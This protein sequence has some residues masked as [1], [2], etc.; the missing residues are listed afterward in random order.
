MTLLIVEDEPKTAKLL[1]KGLIEADF[2]VEIA[3]NGQQA[4]RRARED[5]YD[6]IILDLML[7]GPDG[8]SILE[9]L[10]RL[11]DTTPVLIL[12]ARDGIQ[13][14]VRGLDV[15]ADDYMVK[16]FAVAELL[17]RIRALLRRSPQRQSETLRV[18]DLELDLLSHRA[19]RGA[20]RLDLTPTEFRLLHL[21]AQRTGEVIPRSLI[22]ERV[23]KMDSIPSPNLVDVHVRRLRSKVDDPF[24]RKLVHTVR[25]VGY[26]I[27]DRG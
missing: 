17:A 3:S 23:W 20:V 11:G 14:R 18:G 25:G 13:D 7:P 27:E 15:G 6:A 4:L 8:M 26:V 22:A 2:D 16:P 9:E 24:A 10:R 21:L 5:D 1:R 19:C 12:T